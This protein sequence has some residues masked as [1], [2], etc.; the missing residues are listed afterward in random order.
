MMAT[1]YSRLTQIFAFSDESSLYCAY[2]WYKLY[3]LAITY[4]KKLTEVDVQMLSTSVLLAALGICPYSREN[5]LHREVRSEALAER[6][7][8]MSNILRFGLESKSETAEVYSREAL[9]KE[10]SSETFLSKVPDQVQGLYHLLEHEFNPLGMCRAVDKLT[11]Q[12]SEIS[13]ST[14]SAFPDISVDLSRHTPALKFV[15]VLRML[16]QLAQVYSNMKTSNLVQLVPCMTF[17]EIESI[18][19]NAV[20]SRHIKVRRFCTQQKVIR[21]EPSVLQ[22]RI[23]HKDGSLHF[24]DD[25]LDSENFTQRLSQLAERFGTAQMMIHEPSRNTKLL[26]VLSEAREK[27]HEEH[28]IALAR[29]QL[30]EQR[31][32]EQE[33]FLLE[34]ERAEERKRREQTQQA[35]AAEALRR[36]QEAEKR[37]Q[38]RI[39]R[40]QE[41][42]EI[43]EAKAMLEKGNK[44]LKP[45]QKL[46][47]QKIMQVGIIFHHIRLMMLLISISLKLN[48]SWDDHF[49]PEA[50]LRLF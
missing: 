35:Q 45:G 32:E 49:L 21:R 34:K 48:A 16:Q 46:D 31:K 18:I 26:S 5:A 29:K 1:Y 9:L 30:I 8:R 47:K 27:M 25:N 33:Q 11:E 39:Q 28:E 23:N 37:E 4:N 41:E 43:E 15:A 10:L 12:L 36:Q 17:G 13:R 24:G 19:V 42:R 44:K 50:T 20:K 7:R 22:I 6:Q 3:N 2:A 40:E 38:E 14:S